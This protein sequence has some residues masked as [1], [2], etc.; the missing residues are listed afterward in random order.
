MFSRK[1]WGTENG[2]KEMFCLCCWTVHSKYLKK[3]LLR[4]FHGIQIPRIRAVSLVQ[5]LKRSQQFSLSNPARKTP[6]S[7]PF[8]VLYSSFQ[9]I[10]HSSQHSPVSKLAAAMRT[11]LL[12]RGQLCEKAAY[13]FSLKL[14]HLMQLGLFYLVLSRVDGL[15]GKSKVNCYFQPRALLKCIFRSEIGY[16]ALQKMQ[17]L[18]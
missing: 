1:A 6:P 7:F 2:E 16:S 10:I 9:P 18:F 8:S 5:N 3:C 15:K 13:S 14:S 11:G 4:A 12:L 17:I